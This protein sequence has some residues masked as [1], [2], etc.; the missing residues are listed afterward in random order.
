[1]RVRSGQSSAMSSVRPAYAILSTKCV[2]NLAACRTEHSTRKAWVQYRRSN[3][4]DEWDS[5]TLNCSVIAHVQLF[6]SNARIGPVLQCFEVGDDD[7]CAV[8]EKAFAKAP[9]IPPVPPG[10]QN[11]SGLTGSGIALYNKVSIEGLRSG[12]RE[13]K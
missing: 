10:D 12:R 6:V 11:V 2:T 9:L 5:P 7:V 13:R 1:M 3:S 4:K 8:I